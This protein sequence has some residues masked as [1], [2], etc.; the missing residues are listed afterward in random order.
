MC[1]NDWECVCTIEAGANTQ[2]SISECIVVCTACVLHVCACCACMVFFSR[3]T[4]GEM[5]SFM[6]EN[7]LCAKGFMDFVA[8]C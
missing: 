6:T 1:V 2:H 4:V 7:C 8:A 5:S 3:L